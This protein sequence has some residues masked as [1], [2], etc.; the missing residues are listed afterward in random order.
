MED[1]SHAKFKIRV[2]GDSGNLHDYQFW[3]GTRQA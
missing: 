2:K 3:P 1:S